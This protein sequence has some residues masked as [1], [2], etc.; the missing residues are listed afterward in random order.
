[1][2]EYIGPIGKTSNCRPDLD[3]AYYQLTQASAE[4]LFFACVDAAAAKGCGC[5]PERTFVKDRT[6]YCFYTPP[7]ENFP[8]GYVT[9]YI[10]TVKCNEDCKCK[11]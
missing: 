10:E 11:K 4:A 9:I 3:P 5:A 1:M 2:S 6:I 8:G 7:P